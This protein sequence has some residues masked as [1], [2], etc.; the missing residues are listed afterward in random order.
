MPTARVCAILFLFIA[1]TN[2]STAQNDIS[3]KS[4]NLYEKAKT[5]SIQ[6]D[7]ERKLSMLK[8]AVE[9]SPNYFQA[10]SHLA[11]CYEDLGDTEQQ[12]RCSLKAYE[13]DSSRLGILPYKIASCHLRLKNFDSAKIWLRRYIANVDSGR[14]RT[15]AQRTLANLPKIV[16]LYEGNKDLSLEQLPPEVNS[17]NSEYWPSLSVFEDELIFTRLLPTSHMPQEDFYVSRIVDGE[18]Q[19]AVPLHGAI[20]TPDNEGAQCISSDGKI[21]LYTNCSTDS[22]R[23][24]C[25]I[26]MSVRTDK[27]WSHPFNVGI[28][29]NSTAWDGQPSFSANQKELYFVS[30][31]AGGYGGKD[32]WKCKLK[33]FVD[34]RPVWEEAVNLGSSIN[35]E[36]DDISPFI[37]SDNQTLYFA[38]K[39]WT[40]L[41]NFDIFRA[42]YNAKTGEW[43]EALNLGHPINTE[44]AEQGLFVGRD[45]RT[46]F[47]SSGRN[48]GNKMDIFTF[49]LPEKHLAVPTTYISGTVTD[50]RT[51]EPICAK[52]EFFNISNSQLFLKSHSCMG[53]K[54][55]FLFCLPMLGRFA[56]NVSKDAYLLYSS[57]FRLDSI[58]DVRKPY[59]IDIKLIP[60]DTSENIVLNNIAFDVNSSALL[61]ESMYEIDKLVEFMND[62]P[63]IK[64]ELSGHT[65]NTGSAEHNLELSENR[66]KAVYE[67]LLAKGVNVNRLNFKGFGDAKPI[68]DNAT[69]QGR[70][71]N[72]RTEFK[73][74][75]ML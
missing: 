26:Y 33:G 63:S 31:R 52:M 1:A 28:P 39:G 55:D 36:A 62:N 9:R 13:I 67:A 53:D 25:E 24:S 43:G 48:E 30:N 60:I 69:K 65:D 45:G 8:E 40:N 2:I 22:R 11:Q 47:M 38:S 51:G 44:Q 32:I 58:S 12:L 5:I 6:L 4:I 10:I 61:P 71:A 49:E 23:R 18:W 68:A 34:G 42:S 17:V 20:N 59:N 21:L 64:I 57:T 7:A 29:V 19:E 16:E 3:K 35:T 56:F 72:R 70:D 37:H 27:G 46:A 75:E 74:V 54:G 14:T 50:M 41:G 73:I 66:A 15:A